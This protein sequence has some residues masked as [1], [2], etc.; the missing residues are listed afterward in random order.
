ML[1]TWGCA[2]GRRTKKELRGTGT[3]RF[4][5]VIGSRNA[6]ASRLKELV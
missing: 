5:L 2:L 6:S 3:L 1:A 4:S